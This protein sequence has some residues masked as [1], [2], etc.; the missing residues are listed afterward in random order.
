MIREYA[1]TDFTIEL[2]LDYEFKHFSNNCV[3]LSG[4][5]YKIDTR[6]VHQLIHG[7]VQEKPQRW[8]SS[9]K[10]GSKMAYWTTYQYW[11]TK[12]AKAKGGANQRSRDALDLAHLQ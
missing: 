5:T 10:K 9:L 8:G 12:G 6:K 4:L 2:Q 11:I 7:F 3:P 1:A